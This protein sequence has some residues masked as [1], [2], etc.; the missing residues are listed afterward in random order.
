MVLKP[1]FLRGFK[2]IFSHRKTEGRAEN[3]M[4]KTRFQLSLYGALMEPLWSLYMA[5]YG[6]YMTFSSLLFSSLPRL[7]RSGRLSGTPWDL[8]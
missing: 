8:I 1:H 3:H 4:K 6:L 7:P 5:L 2:T